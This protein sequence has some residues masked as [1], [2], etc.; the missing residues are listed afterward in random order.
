MALRRPRNLPSKAQHHRLSRNQLHSGPASDI[1]SYHHVPFI[2]SF[3]LT[4]AFSSLA[5]SNF[6]DEFAVRSGAANLN[7]EF[8]GFSFPGMLLDIVKREGAAIEA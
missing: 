3:S 2:H 1:D 5:Q 8:S 4:G 7:V 6:A